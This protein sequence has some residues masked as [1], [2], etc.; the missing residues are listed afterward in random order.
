M[1]ELL[2]DLP[3][4]RD[5]WLPEFTPF[6]PNN[7]VPSGRPNIVFIFADDLGWG[8]LGCFGSLHNATP[9]IDGIAADGLRLTHAYA[10][11]ATCSPTRIGFY[12]GRYPGRL[13]AGLE[14]PLT[15]RDEHHGIPHQHPTLQSLLK[16]AGYRTGMFGKWH[17][18]W[19]PWFSPIKSGFETFFGN[20]DGAMDYFSHI[21]T[22]GVHD[23]YEG[24]VE[25]EEVGYYTEIVAAKSA[26]YIASHAH[27]PFYLQVNFTAPHWPWEGPNDL[28]TSRRVTEA[29]LAGTFTGIFDYEGGSL[30]KY[31]EM[32]ASLDDGVGRILDAIDV[33]GINDNT[34]VIF[35]SDNGGE[36]FAYLWPFL[37]EKG[38]LE[39]GGI[40]VPFV[41]K[42]PAQL[43]SGQSSSEISTTMD[44]T[45]TLLEAAGVAPDPA[46]ALDGISLLPWLRHGETPQERMLLW[47]TREQGAARWGKYKLLHDR[48]A[49]PFWSDENGVEGPRTRLFDVSEEGREWADL[50]AEF[51]EIFE[52]MKAAWF[53]FDSEMLPYPEERP[54]TV[55]ESG[56]PD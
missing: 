46:F 18:G 6:A 25:V 24:E 33:A 4:R 20:L 19:L 13:V 8:D 36:R 5:H 43:N 22:A 7:Q 52:R 3:D 45:A 11:S 55:R 49:K 51:P 1:T 12:T 54:V 44:W 32:V 16:N 50:S 53:A 37:G 40:R 17:C 23:L 28:E 41:M 42:W 38:H 26:E 48:T 30:A 27:E 35:T 29:Q 15:T 39:E 2:G 10:T 21:D 47:R 9:H 31:R 14:E 56:E 34:I